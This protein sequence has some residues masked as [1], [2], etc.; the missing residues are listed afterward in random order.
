[1]TELLNTPV[2]AFT[3]YLDVSTSLYLERSAISFG[4]QHELQRRIKEIQECQTVIYDA[5]DLS[6]VLYRVEY[7]TLRATV[8]PRQGRVWISGT[9]KGGYACWSNMSDAA[10]KALSAQVE[11]MLLNHAKAQIENMRQE[12]LTVL[13]ASIRREMTAMQANLQQRLQEVEAEE[14]RV[15]RGACLPVDLPALEF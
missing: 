11:G 6:L 14:Q 1:M 3:A 12:A 8:F 5:R 13:F 2:A 7:D 10:R 9:R 15:M 4:I